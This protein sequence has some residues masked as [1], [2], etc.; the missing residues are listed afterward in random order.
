VYAASSLAESSS[1]NESI[2]I[3]E[4]EPSLVGPQEICIQKRGAPLSSQ[5]HFRNPFQE[6]VNRRLTNEA[7][8]LVITGFT[9]IGTSPFSI[10]EMVC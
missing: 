9:G 7:T 5:E 6:D 2:H 1:L 4:D 8:V 3:K 10:I